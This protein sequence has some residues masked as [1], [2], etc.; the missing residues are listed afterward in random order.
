MFQNLSSKISLRTDDAG[1]LVKKLVE[2][3]T[4]LVQGEAYAEIEVMKM[5][6]PL[7]VDEARHFLVFQRGLSIITR[8]TCSNL[9]T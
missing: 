8:I 6:M 3:G 7:K 2:D 5:F 4:K 1:K 9:A